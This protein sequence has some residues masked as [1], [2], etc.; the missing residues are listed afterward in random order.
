LVDGGA[1]FDVFRA[2][3]FVDFFLPAVFFLLLA[4]ADSLLPDVTRLECRGRCRTAVPA[5]SANDAL[6]NTAMTAA[7]SLLMQKVTIA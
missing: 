3:V 1:F 4:G 6:T 2:A 5:A 7:S